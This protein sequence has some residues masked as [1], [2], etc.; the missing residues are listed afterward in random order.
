LG[1]TEPWDQRG[2]YTAIISTEPVSE[3]VMILFSKSITYKR[4][5]EYVQSWTMTTQCFTSIRNTNTVAGGE[6]SKGLFKNINAQ[7]YDI[8][9]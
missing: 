8:T 1:N 7:G 3:T 9:T 4:T 6:L 5:E 2:Y